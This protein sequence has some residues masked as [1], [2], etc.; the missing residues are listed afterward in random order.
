MTKFY[1]TSNQADR[2]NLDEYSA[3]CGDA[4]F[5]SLRNMPLDF[6]RQQYADA[7]NLASSAENLFQDEDSD[8]DYYVD[9]IDEANARWVTAWARGF[10]TAFENFLE[11]ETGRNGKN[12]SADELP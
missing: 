2:L 9:E 1:L 12:E 5:Q 8:E 3:D 10:K 6:L 7:E 11:T 4:A